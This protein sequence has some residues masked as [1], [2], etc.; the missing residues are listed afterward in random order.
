M[1][2]TETAFVTGATGQDGS[3]LVDRLLADGVEVHALVH[4][5]AEQQGPIPSGVIEHRGSLAD[6]DRLATLV[7][8]IEPD[9]VFNLAGISSVATSWEHPLD[10][11]QISGTSVVALLEACTK[12]RDRGRDVRIVQASSSEIFG[13]A[14]HSPQNES[15][16][17]RPVSPYGAAKALAH[18]AVSVY[19]GRGLFSS[20]AV[21]Y[22]HESPRRPETFV[23]RKIT[24]GVARIAAGLESTISLGNLEARR[25]WGWA[26]DYVDA[27]LRI[28]R[29]DMPG[30]Y[31]VATGETHSVREF[32]AAAFFAAGIDE[33]EDR[34]V[35][36]PSFLRPADVHE[37]RGD[38][39]K[40][41]TDLGWAPTM[42]FDAIVEAMVRHD[43][44]L[45]GLA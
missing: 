43:L 24:S 22:N 29:A 14:D 44:T 26:P 30:D 38:S 4:R 7:A 20:T 3:Y 13:A 39:I 31:V 25:D 36:D 8:S 28:A 12:L 23:T 35:V 37:M 18:H 33:W 2:R 6:F 16:P 41:R 42:G 21:L 40:A 11:V 10:T 17:I 15:T 45:L 27:I 5:G 9:V 1:S 32:V 19:R 34:L